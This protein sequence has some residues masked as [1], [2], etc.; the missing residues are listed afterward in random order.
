MPSEVWRGLITTKME[1]MNE[2]VQTLHETVLAIIKSI[3]I[4]TALLNTI[5]AC[6]ALVYAV[7]SNAS[8][9]WWFMP[10]SILCGG[11][12][13]LANFRWLALAV[14]RKLA[15]KIAP[16]DRPNAVRALLTGLK[17]VA[18]FIALFVIIKWQLLHIFGL[19]TGLSLC[20]VTLVWEGL[21]RIG[22]TRGNE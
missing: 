10:F 5:A 19:L 4:K 20:F 12:L 21:A 2:Q 6:A 16:A 9:D 15:S 11:V 7:I 3:S 8:V 13:G 14:E 1:K 18:I 17:L 22:S